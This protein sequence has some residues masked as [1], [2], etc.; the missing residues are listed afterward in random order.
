MAVDHM[1]VS[2]MERIRRLLGGTADRRATVSSALSSSARLE[3]GLFPDPGP[4]DQSPSETF[5]LAPAV[6]WELQGGGD[7]AAN[8]RTRLSKKT[9]STS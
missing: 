8:R 7:S 5:A 2:G 6:P 4:F 3:D 1:G 9:K